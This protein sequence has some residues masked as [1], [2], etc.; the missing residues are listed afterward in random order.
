MGIPF[1]DGSIPDK[2]DRHSDHFPVRIHGSPELDMIDMAWKDS[3][4]AG[5]FVADM[6]DVMRE[7]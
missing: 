1:E 4:V 6:T 7:E 3:L 2:T 5:D